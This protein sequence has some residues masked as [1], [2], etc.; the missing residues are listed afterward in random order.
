MRS[1][2]RPSL[3]KASLLASLDYMIDAMVGT[4]KEEQ[5]DDDLKK[6]YCNGQLDVTDDKK[7]AVECSL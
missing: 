4:V 5:K 2:C 1:E 6:E 3:S 7:E